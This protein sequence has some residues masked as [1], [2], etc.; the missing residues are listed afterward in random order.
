MSHVLIDRSPDLLKLSRSGFYI[1]IVDEAYLVVHD[2]PYVTASKTIQRSDLVFVLTLGGDRTVKPS[3]HVA[4]WSGEHPYYAN[5]STL[6]ALLQPNSIRSNL[7]PSYTSVLMFSAKA[8]YRDYFHK[9]TTYVEILAREARS[10]K[11]GISALRRA[12]YVG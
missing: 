5:G 7:T 11:P 4:Y 9:V 3:D 2:V 10:I 1:D 6:D 12:E 8:D